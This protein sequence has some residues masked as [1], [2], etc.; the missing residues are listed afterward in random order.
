MVKDGDT[1]ARVGVVQA[2]V[3]LPLVQGSLHHDGGDVPSS[4]ERRLG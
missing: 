3:D 1:R 4:T 2:V